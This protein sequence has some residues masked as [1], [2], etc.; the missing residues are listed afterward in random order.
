M[1]ITKELIET[2]ESNKNIKSVYFETATGLHHFNH[3]QTVGKGKEI[4]L[5]INGKEVEEVSS[6]DVKKMKVSHKVVVDPKTAMI[7]YEEVSGKTQVKG[8]KEE[9]IL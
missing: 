3:A 9:I 5:V 4:K 6:D 2:L 8:N 1:K 7:G